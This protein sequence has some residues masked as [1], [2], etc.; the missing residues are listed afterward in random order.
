MVRA[1][2]D[3]DVNDGDKFDQEVNAI[4]TYI[5]TVQSCNEFEQSPIVIFRRT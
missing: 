1:I 5:A 2:F 3:L 4:L